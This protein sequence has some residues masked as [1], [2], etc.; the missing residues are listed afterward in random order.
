ML[1]IYNYAVLLLV[2]TSFHNPVSAYLQSRTDSGAKLSW[3][4]ASVDLVFNPASAGPATSAENILVLQDSLNAWS[5]AEANVSFSLTA[6]ENQP[7]LSGRDSV[8][9]VFFASN[10]DESP[11]NGVLA[12][13][14]IMFNT[15]TGEIVET[16][17]IFNDRDYQFS[18]DRGDRTGIFLG[19]VATHEVGHVLGLDHTT[20]N[21]GTMVFVHTPGMFQLSN[22]EVAAV[23]S[24]Y[25]GRALAGITG[26]ATANNERLAGSHIVAINQKDGSIAAATMAEKDGSF[27]VAGLPDGDYIL[28]AERFKAPVR[29]IS[30]Y[31]QTGIAA[32]VCDGDSFQPTFFR[33]CRDDGRALAVPVRAGE[34]VRVGVFAPQCARMGGA[35]LTSLPNARVVPAA[36]GAFYET[37]RE[38]GSHYYKLSGFSGSLRANVVA[39]AIFSSGD[40]IVEL[41]NAAG[42]KID[43][44]LADNQPQGA[45]GAIKYDPELA[46]D[47]LPAGDYYLRVRNT[48]TLD[49]D[50]YSAGDEL[51]EDQAFYLLNVLTTAGSA[52]SLNEDMQACSVSDTDDGNGSNE[53]NGDAAGGCGSID[54][55]SLPPWYNNT[56]L[57]IMLMALI[58]KLWFTRPVFVSGFPRLR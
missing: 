12:L 58:G 23:G 46:A 44:A 18:T 7:V 37:L 13:T 30:S 51:R 56:I 17:L 43:V 49:K 15:L 45:N 28:F 48:R 29:T 16:D 2:T 47:A 8:N 34:S 14:R 53:G 9:A 22:D 42:K 11:G 27:S 35:T 55:G 10:S 31:W 33:S 52:A 3:R 40:F 25:G 4:T 41:L 6:G 1:K 54:S 21:G 19:D 50:R 39:H 5:D 36:G 32:D 24:I 26:E 38:E 57:L 20:V